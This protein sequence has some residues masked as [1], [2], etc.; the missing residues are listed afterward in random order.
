[1]YSKHCWTAS[2]QTVCEHHT[3]LWKSIFCHSPVQIALSLWEETADLLQLAQTM[4][5]ATSRESIALLPFSLSW[6]KPQI[7]QLC[8]HLFTWSN[9]ALGT[10]S[11][12]V[13]QRTECRTL[14]WPK[15]GANTLK[16]TLSMCFS[17]L[18][19]YCVSILEA[20]LL[21]IMVHIFWGSPYF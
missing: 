4:R 5:T 21:S 15:N 7:W 19:Y 14:C 17:V 11:V 20:S 3:S 2:R 18:V 12:I 16:H 6:I 9:I 10:T 1:M 8:L 13:A